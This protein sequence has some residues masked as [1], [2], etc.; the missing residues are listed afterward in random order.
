MTRTLQVLGC[1]GL[2][3]LLLALAPQNPPSEMQEMPASSTSNSTPPASQPAGDDEDGRRTPRQIEILRD[4][5]RE[6]ERPAPIIPS[7][8][9][10]DGET[11]RR[12][13]RGAAA[14]DSRLLLEGT[15]I[16]ERPGRFI[17]EDDRP[18]FTL[19]LPGE[20][21]SRTMEFNRNEL[22]E[23]LER[24]ARSGVNE[25]VISAQVSRYRGQN[26][27]S[28]LKVLERVPNGNLSP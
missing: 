9:R 11:T 28:L 8:Q 26:Y 27:L 4:L 14:A 19:T 5:I 12:I 15:V 1:F 21:E 23:A 7:R 2:A 10:A 18:R 3:A 25:F 6:R 24:V 17:I 16:V 20:A 22:L 13:E